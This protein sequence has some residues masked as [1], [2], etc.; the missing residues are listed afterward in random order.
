MGVRGLGGKHPRFGNQP[1]LIVFHGEESL[2]EQIG[3]GGR[4]DAAA[5][6]GEQRAAVM[7]LQLANVLG[8]GGLRDEQGL[9]RPREAALSIG[10]KERVGPV[11]EHI[12]S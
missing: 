10:L 2:V 8:D 1:T 5:R 12:A 4:L 7:C 3:G 9:R 6:F 11:V